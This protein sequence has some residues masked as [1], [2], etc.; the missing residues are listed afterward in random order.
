MDKVQNAKNRGQYG[1]NTALLA[2]ENNSDSGAAGVA[3][4]QMTV[5]QPPSSAIPGIGSVGDGAAS[6]PGALGQVSFPYV[7]ATI[8]TYIRDLFLNLL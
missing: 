6:V 8:D 7:T 1:T 2:L 3:G 4:Q 5:Y